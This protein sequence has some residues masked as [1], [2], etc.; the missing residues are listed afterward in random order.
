[1]HRIKLVRPPRNRWKIRLAA[2]ELERTV[3]ETLDGLARIGE[4]ASGPEDFIEEPVFIRLAA[5][6][7]VD[8]PTPGATDPGG[9]AAPP[10]AVRGGGLT[11]PKHLPARSNH[12]YLEPEPRPRDLLDSTWVPREREEPVR[13]YHAGGQWSRPAAAFADHEWALRGFTD[14]EKDVWLAA[15]LSEMQS[16]VAEL[17]RDERLSPE[18]LSADLGGWTVLQRVKL[19]EDVAAVLRL[20]YRTLGHEAG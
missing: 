2:K 12:P 1:M 3:E 7:G 19:G 18:A 4:Y 13:D 16:K 17:L 14:A 5:H 20:L 9:T 8:L 6:F 11:P 10:T 15:G